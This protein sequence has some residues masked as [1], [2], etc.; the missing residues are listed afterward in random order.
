MNNDPVDSAESTNFTIVYRCGFGVNAVY[1]N[2][3][4][5]LTVSAPPEFEV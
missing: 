3:L 1:K 2:G 5:H 4:I